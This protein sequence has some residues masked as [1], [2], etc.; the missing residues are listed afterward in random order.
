V[1]TPNNNETA[2]AAAGDE[3]AGLP[4]DVHFDTQ[5]RV[6]QALIDIMPDRIYAKDA[7][8]RFILANK[9][10]AKL[11]GK[12]SPEEMMGK[13]DFHFYPKELAS[14]YF[15]VEQ[16]MLQSGQPLIAF[17]QMVPN[18]ETGEP[19]WLQ[20]TKVPL[21]DNEGTVIGLV[22]LA[23]DITE[24]KRFEAEIR[25]RNAELAELNQK[26]SQAQEQLMQSEKLAAIGHLA[27][28]VAHEI[29]N[30]IGFIFSNFNTLDA[31][32]KKFHDMLTAFTDAQRCIADPCVVEKLE[33]LRKETDLDF[34]LED[35]QELITETRKGLTRVKKIVQDLR[36][37]SRV[38]AT[39]QWSK[40][41]LRLC[42][43]STLNILANDIRNKA[44]VV[45]LYDDIPQVECIAP[46]MTQVIMNL[47]INA[48]DAM[49]AERGTITVRTGVVTSP[50]AGGAQ[51]WFEVS[52]T[53]SGIAKD[54]LPHIFDPFYTTKPVGKGTGL[55]LSLSYGIVQGHNG[56]IDVTSELGAGSS[57][58]VTLPVTQAKA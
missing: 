2:P 12:T 33:R 44:D 1:I 56:R 55:G 10:V 41:D 32:M 51:A 50:G 9:A 27:A 34:L 5:A 11:M 8:S 25:K 43:D 4:G 7:Q 13:D 38:D 45:Q 15:E 35:S 57:F 16:A 48:A 20:T 24:R 19:G 17:E 49:G 28:G 46:Q 6:F 3:K 18:L 22:G 47:L 52:D 37:F 21:R 26:L 53:G 14:Q 36:D 31:Y 58:R 39:A 42:I 40:T 23:R 30:P 54:V 29:N